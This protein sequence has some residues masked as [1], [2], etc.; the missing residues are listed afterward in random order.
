MS[1]ERT[2]LLVIGC[3][4]AGATAAREAAR[5]GV[6]TIVLEKDAVIGAKRVCAAGLR[7]GFCSD[8]DLSRDI[9]HCDTPRLALFDARGVEHALRFGPGHTTTREELDGAIAQL[10][11]AEGADIRT[12]MLFRDVR[13]ERDSIV[14]TYADLAGG[15]RKEIAAHALFFAQGSTAVLESTPLG[16]ARWRS[17]LMT[18]L[19]YRVYLEQPAAPIA[20]ESLEMHYY[21]GQEGRQ[22]VGWM[23]PKKD[24]LAIGLGVVGKMEG[25]S[26]RQELDAFTQ[27]VAARL[28]P[29]SA[30]RAV[31][32]E[33]HLLYMEAPRDVL[34]H[35]GAAV[36]GTAAGFVDATN[37]EGI[38]EA[39]LSG[40]L[41]ADALH[42]HRNDPR[43]ATRRYAH[44]V[45]SRFVK[46]LQHRV[47]LMHFL[48]RKPERFGVLFE[49]LAATPHLPEVLHAEG[50][51]RTVRDRVF[52]YAQMA[53]FLAKSA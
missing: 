48:E 32:T 53:R 27:R 4:P 51:R 44:A 31:K 28:Y 41:F 16:Y 17:G 24:H 52:L 13:F 2:E 38:Y 5:A 25:H 1:V 18:T 30:V 11:L 15:T 9:V 6:Q 14:A 36:G 8:F 20:Y 33:G 22:V 49:Q 3:G 42:R 47:K 39:A 26:L 21:L 10:A 50:N 45:R 35:E 29:A 23:F 19:Q 37:G 46:R 34:R 7:P 12:R 40:R 43:A